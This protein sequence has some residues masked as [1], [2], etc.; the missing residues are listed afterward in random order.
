[1]LPGETRSTLAPS[2][3]GDAAVELRD[4]VAA[5]ARYRDAGR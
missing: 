1:L 5:F 4:T 3:G 2:A